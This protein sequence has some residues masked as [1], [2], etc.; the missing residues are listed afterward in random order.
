MAAKKDAT[1]KKKMQETVRKVHQEKAY[2][3]WNEQKC[4]SWWVK[5]KASDEPPTVEQESVLR[6]VEGRCQQEKR[7]L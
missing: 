7:E 3:S 6:C 5:V 4:A 1:S 2:C